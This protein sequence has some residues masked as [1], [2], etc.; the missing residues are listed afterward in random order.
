M[1]AYLSEPVTEK[2]SSDGGGEEEACWV[3]YGAS[4]MQ[5]WRVSQ[6]D[7]HNSLLNFDEDTHIFAVYDGHGGHEVS[8]YTALKLPDYFKNTKAYRNGCL[9]KALVDTF[10]GFDATLVNSEVVAQLKVIAGTKDDDDNDDDSDSESEDVQDLYREATMPLDQVMARYPHLQHH[11]KDKVASPFLKAKNS[12]GGG[13]GSSVGGISSET[14]TTT[15]TTTEFDFPSNQD[16]GSSG[17]SSGEKS[18]TGDGHHTTTEMNGEAPKHSMVNGED[19]A[20][21]Q[22]EENGVI[23]RKENGKKTTKEEEEENKKEEGK[24]PGSTEEVKENGDLVSNGEEQ[25]QQHQTGKGKGKGSG[26]GGKGKAL[27]KNSEIQAMKE[28]KAKGSRREAAIRAAAIRAAEI[29]RKI[30]EGTGEGSI[31]DEPSDE[32]EDDD[33]NFEEEEEEEEEGEAEGEEG[34][35]DEEG[36]ESED[37]DDDDD[38]DVEVEDDDDPY[39]EFAMN[40]KEEPGYDS[41]CTACVAVIRGGRL[42]VANVGDSRCVVSRDGQALDLS[43][44]HKPEDDPEAARIIRARGRVTADGRVNGGLNLSRAIGDHG[45]KQNKSLGAEEQMI[46]PLP[47]VRSLALT[48]MDTFM[49]VAC[50]GIWNSLTSQEACDFVSERIQQDMKLS[51]ICEELFDHCMAPDTHGDGT[52]CDNMTCII[53]KFDSEAVKARSSCNPEEGVVVEQ[54]DLEKTEVQTHDQK[55]EEEEEE[56]EDVKD[57]EVKKEKEIIKGS[58][59]KMDE[60]KASGGAGVKRGAKEAELGSSST[61]EKK[62]KPS[63]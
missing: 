11:T 27:L 62:L 4:S 9:P 49:I 63:E 52:G 26:K 22:E 60:A 18:N 57:K 7:A 40:M 2:L 5:G 1:G 55:E 31:E 8:A 15:T 30:Q 61:E 19:D 58:L 23:E 3:S 33:D 14:T 39:A 59:S 12:C 46:S 50:D 28:A 32:D 36:E 17:S 6:E 34:G 56:E 53:I 42:I 44:D 29:Y 38:D 51:K 54:V 35:E 25:Q 20:K 41:G 47:D 10:L 13:S 37:D 43:I 24:S 21:E 16:D 48:P 45:Y